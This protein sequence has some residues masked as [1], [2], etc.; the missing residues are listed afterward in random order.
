MI[1]DDQPIMPGERRCLAL[2]NSLKLLSP[3]QRNA[4]VLHVLAPPGPD[5]G[6]EGEREV[7]QQME[8][9]ETNV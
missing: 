4:T 5:H 7:R 8:M 9:V 2:A 3:A 6:I 1:P